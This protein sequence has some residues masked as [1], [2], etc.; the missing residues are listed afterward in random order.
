MRASDWGKRG[1]GVESLT[2]P[3]S[4]REFFDAHAPDYMGNVFTQ[5]TEAE[6]DFVIKELNLPAGSRILDIGCGTGRHSVKLARRGYLMTGVDQSG[7]M[8]A[9]ARKA[10]REAHVDVEWVQAD[11]REFS[12]DNAFDAAICLCE[13]AFGLLETAGEAI[14]QPLAILRNIA[15]SLKPGGKAVFTVLNGFRMIRAHKQ[16]DVESGAFDPL[17]LSELSEEP[18]AIGQH[19][20][21]VRERGFVPTELILLFERAGLKPLHIWGGTA[22]AWNKAKINLDE[23]EI[24][25]IAERTH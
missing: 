9:Q 18:P 4:W 7:G 22:G 12:R 21:Q 19:G 23:Y 5:N 24:M 15:A 13:G 17:T 6:V 2:E 8:L 16:D 14:G 20:V 25:I 1:Y 10:A 11:A 3:K